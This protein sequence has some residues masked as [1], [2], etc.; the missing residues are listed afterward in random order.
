MSE[1]NRQLVLRHRPTGAVTAD[2]FELVEEAIPDVQASQILVRTLWLGFDPAQRGWLN[3][4][5]SYM[6]PVA[7]GEVMR[8]WG[9]GEVVASG[10]VSYPVGSLVAGPVGWQTHALMD[11]ADAD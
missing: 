4:V 7:I 8:A 6:P 5:R 3:D 1:P 9:V 10:D 11:T 2:C